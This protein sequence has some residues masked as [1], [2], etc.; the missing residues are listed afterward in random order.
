MF[1]QRFFYIIV[2]I[3]LH[4]HFPSFNGNWWCTFTSCHFRLPFHIIVIFSIYN[5]PL[6]REKHLILPPPFNNCI[7][8]FLNSSA[9]IFLFYYI[10]F[11][12]GNNLVIQDIISHNVYLSDSRC[13]NIGWYFVPPFLYQPPESIDDSF[14]WVSFVRSM[15]LI[16]VF[17]KKFLNNVSFLPHLSTCA[18]ALAI[19]SAGRPIAEM[20]NRHFYRICIS[21]PDMIPLLVAGTASVFKGTNIFFQEVNVYGWSI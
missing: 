14:F 15:F 12:W 11:A 3:F 17:H 16:V 18:P 21:F 8:F 2:W 1:F 9:S 19:A 7:S 6:S 10:S 5:F 4:T 20:P 13:W